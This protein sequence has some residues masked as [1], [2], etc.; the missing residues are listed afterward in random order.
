MVFLATHNLLNTEIGATRLSAIKP[1]NLTAKPAHSKGCAALCCKHRRIARQ[2]RTVMNAAF[3]LLK[4]PPL[5]LLTIGHAYVNDGRLCEVQ[6]AAN[7]DAPQPNSIGVGHDDSTKRRARQSNPTSAEVVINSPCAPDPWQYQNQSR[8]AGAYG[9]GSMQGER[10][11]IRSVNSWHE[12]GANTSPFRK[13]PQL[14]QSPSWP[15]TGPM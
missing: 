12:A 3:R 13:C 6:S 7:A 1:S 4:D 15:G 5:C 14:S 8:P 2:H 9:S 10:S 11:S